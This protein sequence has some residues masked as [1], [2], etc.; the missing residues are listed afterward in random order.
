MCKR[1]LSTV[2]K[3]S[4]KKLSQQDMEEFWCFLEGLLHEVTSNSRRYFVRDVADTSSIPKGYIDEDILIMENDRYFVSFAVSLE[5]L[6]NSPAWYKF[7]TSTS[8][9]RIYS[10]VILDEVKEACKNVSIADF[11]TLEVEILP[12]SV[13]LF[14]NIESKIVH[15][16]KVETFVCAL[17][18]KFYV[19]LGNQQNTQSQ[20]RDTPA[21][22][23][24]CD[25]LYY[26]F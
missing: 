5:H 19:S 23:R 22:V 17:I 13:G 18:F 20:M 3:S 7:E 1:V 6:E 8:T 4:R 25:S 26:C 10:G 21:F 11:S 15:G 14:K 2:K 16:Q 9:Y 24:F 12:K